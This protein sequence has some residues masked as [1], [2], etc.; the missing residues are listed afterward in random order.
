MIDETKPCDLKEVTEMDVVNSYKEDN[1]SLKNEI[2]KG[3]T[4]PRPKISRFGEKIEGGTIPRWG[5]IVRF[6]V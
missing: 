4:I 3:G 1:E 5:T 2:I 6:M